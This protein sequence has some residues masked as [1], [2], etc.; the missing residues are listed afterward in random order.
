MNTALGV[1]VSHLNYIVSF[2]DSDAFDDLSVSPP[3]SPFAHCQSLNQLL[4]PVTTIESHLITNRIKDG[5]KNADD[6][7][8]CKE[9]HVSSD[10][11]TEKK[12]WKKKRASVKERIHSR[13]CHICGK[14]RW[15]VA[16]LECS[17]IT[18]T[19]CSKV[20][21]KSCFVKNGWAFPVRGTTY[22]CAHC[23]Q[24]CPQNATC[25]TYKRSNLK[26]RRAQL[27]SIQNGSM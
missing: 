23:N 26:R 11:Q 6:G 22:L 3:D 19:G 20:V 14:A 12:S 17:A 16:V 21:C 8:E 7:R 15:S 5:E 1:H 10:S 4:M 25:H 27:D 18:T 24:Q 2:D 13:Y 9:E